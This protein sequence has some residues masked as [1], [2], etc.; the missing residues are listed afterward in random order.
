[1][2]TSIVSIYHHQTLSSFVNY[3]KCLIKQ[4]VRKYLN[5]RLIER[6]I[7]NIIFGE[8]FEILNLIKHTSKYLIVVAQI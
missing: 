2:C 5:E 1:M 8:G 7:S 4:F 3:I 6:I